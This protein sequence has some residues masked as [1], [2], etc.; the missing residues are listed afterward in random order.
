VFAVA[1]GAGFAVLDGDH[2]FHG[3]D[4]AGF[5]DGVDVFA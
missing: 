1:A 5:E 2:G 3:D 4:H